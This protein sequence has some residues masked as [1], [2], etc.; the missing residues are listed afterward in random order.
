M[1][2]KK[3]DFKGCEKTGTCRCPKDRNLSDYWLFCQKH[4]A[5][6]NKNWNYYAGMSKEEVDQVW[7]DDM[8]G[9]A[10]QSPEASAEY[11]KLIHD[12]LTGNE[13]KAPRK[14]TLPTEVAAA[15]KVLGIASLDDWAATQKKF[16]ALAK[17][18]HPDTKKD[19]GHGHRF[20]E[21]NNAYQTLKK[22]LGK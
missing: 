20:S 1:V 15:L 8:F 10:K 16:R 9:P 18:E 5:E 14:R 17:Q 13:K 7:E 3:C 6:Y 19:K 2:V 12:F 4:A 11:Q 22:F 21:I